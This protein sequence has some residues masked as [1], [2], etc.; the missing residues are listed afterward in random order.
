[1]VFTF[2][3][4]QKKKFKRFQHVRYEQSMQIKAIFRPKKVMESEVTNNSSIATLL[5]TTIGTHLRKSCEL[6]GKQLMSCTFVLLATSK[7]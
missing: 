1:M 7:A 2:Q 3:T 4:K 6:A 5:D